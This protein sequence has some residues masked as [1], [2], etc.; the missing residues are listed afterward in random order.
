LTGSGKIEVSRPGFMIGIDDSDSNKAK[1]YFGDHYGYMSWN[2]DTQEVRGSVE[3]NDFHWFTLFE[4]IDGYATA[5]TVNLTA[6]YVSIITAATTNSVSELQKTLAYHSTEFTWDKKRKFRTN[7][8]FQDD[9]LQTIYIV[10]GGGQNATDK[11]IGFFVL[12]GDL[13]GVTADGAYGHTLDIGV[14][15][16]AGNTY[17]LETV[18][19]P[20]DRCEFYVNGAFKGMIESNLP[21]GTGAKEDWFLDVYVKTGEDATKEVRLSYWDLWQQF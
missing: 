15:I 18:F 10:A 9:T 16:T 6:G 12:N 5:G 21:S 14:A 17:V 8:N 11:K 19:Y 7:I 20:G 2:G 13:Y 4:S 3:R 1:L